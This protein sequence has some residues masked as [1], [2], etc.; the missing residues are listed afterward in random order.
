MNIG[1]KMTIT[2]DDVMIAS[3]T[4]WGE[5]RGEHMEGKMAIAHVLMNR[6]R[7]TTGQWAKDDTLAKTCLRPW[8]FSAWNSDDPNLPKMQKVDVNDKLFRECMIAVLTACN[9]PQDDPTSGSRHY[10]TTALLSKGF[11]KRWGTPRK[12]VTV[13]GSHAFFNN[14]K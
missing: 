10:I 8:Q 2:L 9:N 7:S 13:I 1:L 5:G 4:L 14:I 6:W 3:R 11:P 12:P